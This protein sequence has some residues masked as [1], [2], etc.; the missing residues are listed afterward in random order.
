MMHS[1]WKMV[2]L[3]VAAIFIIILAT[4][5]YQP[6]AAKT[7]SL[8]VWT[9]NRIYIMDIDT[10]NLERIGPANPDE[11]IT[12]SPGC[13]GQTETPCWVV[14]SDRLYLVDLGGAANSVQVILPVDPGSRMGESV[15]WAPDGIHLAYSTVDEQIIRSKLQIYNAQTNKVEFTLPEPDSTIAVAWTVGCAQGLQASGCE[16]GYKTATDRGVSHLVGY[17]P[18]TQERREWDI[19]AERIFELRWSPN[20]VL[21][22]SRPKRHFINPQEHEPAHQIPPGSRLANLSPDARYAVYY[23]PFTLADCESQ[24]EEGR[25]LH[26]GVWLTYLDKQDSKSELIYSVDLSEADRTGGL[27]FIPTWSP[28]G[29]SF[30]FFQEGRLVHYDLEEKEALIW[31]KPVSG[32]LRSTP[33]FSPN[34]EAVAF[35]DNQGQGFSEYRLVIVDPKLQ[36]IEHVIDTKQGFQILAWL[37]N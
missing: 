7:G 16:L 22:Y 28:Q 33:V 1:Q 3:W 23:Q 31:Y 15:S 9:R 27:N 4:V 25:C 19:L 32:K 10:L 18:A 8:L 29:D 14:A 21:L 12:P 20:D 35:V 37:P 26:L 13:I 24:G 2:V 17:N 6:V 30:V 11:L 34:E 5:F 36:P